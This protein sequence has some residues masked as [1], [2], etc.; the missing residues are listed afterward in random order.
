MPIEI[1]TQ[2]FTSGNVGTAAACYETTLNIQGGNCSNVPA[3]RAFT[4][5]SKAETCTGNF[6]LPAKV[7]GG[8]CFEF[9]A[10]NPDYSAFSTF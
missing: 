8:Y 10:G 9:S 5:N 1:K 4:I 3:P 6:T 2:T 7:N